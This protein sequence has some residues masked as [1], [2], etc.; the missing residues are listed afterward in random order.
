LGKGNVAGNAS[1]HPQ[2]QELRQVL[3]EQTIEHYL[4]EGAKQYADFL[5]AAEQLFAP[6]AQ[7][8]A[9]HREWM[10]ETLTG[11]SGD[12]SQQVSKVTAAI[13]QQDQRI[14]ASLKEAD[15]RF[16]ARWIYVCLATFLV[17]AI[18]GFALGY[19]RP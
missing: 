19:W 17:A 11:F 4:S 12:I 3:L 1:L 8:M 7:Q 9:N 10:K 14:A 15:R 6:L 16:Y 18:S 5:K 2:T 13:A